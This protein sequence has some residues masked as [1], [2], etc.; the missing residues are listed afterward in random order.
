MKKLIYQSVSV[1]IIMSFF[2]VSGCVSSRNRALKSSSHLYLKSYDEVW[3]AMN[4]LLLNDM[5]CFPETADK[6]SGK[7]ETGWVHTIDLD[8]Y[9]KWRIKARV[10][11]KKNGV[12][13]EIDKMAQVKKDQRQ[14]IG[15]Y[16]EERM[17]HEARNT[18]DA[19]TWR[20]LEVDKAEIEGMHRK[21]SIKLNR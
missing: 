10:K 4:D 16:A 5:N 21:L 20:T 3:E 1:L 17:K 9:N 11:K 14:Q 7:I 15:M 13:V 6:K 2:L 19:S 12:Y 8:G 18:A